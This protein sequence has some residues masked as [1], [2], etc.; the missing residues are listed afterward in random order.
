MFFLKGLRPE[1]YRDNQA[2]I[3]LS[4]PRQINIVIKGWITEKAA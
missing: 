1:R 3:T 2:G 4:G